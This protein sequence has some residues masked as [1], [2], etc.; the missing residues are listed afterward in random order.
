MVPPSRP[1]S[2]RVNIQGRIWKE[3]YHR[4][5]VEKTATKGRRAHQEAPENI[6]K[7]DLYRLKTD[8]KF[9]FRL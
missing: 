4:E 2:Y 5:C 9:H 3:Y 7:F 6:Y 8:T 1:R